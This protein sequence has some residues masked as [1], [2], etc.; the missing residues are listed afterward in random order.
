M[1][2]EE[3]HLIE[4]FASYLSGRSQ[5]VSVGGKCSESLELN[6][7]VPQGSC[8]RPLLF[9]LY[10]SKLFEVVKRHLPSVHAYADDTQLYLAFKPGCASSADDAIAAMER[11]GNEIRAWMLCDKLMI[12]DG[13]TDFVIIGTR[14]QL[15]KVHIDSLAVGDAHVSPVQSVKNLG[16]WI[17]SNMSL[18]VNIN[19]TCRPAYCYITNV[20]Q[21]RKYLSNQATQTLVHA[22][23][24]GRIDY[25][26]SIL[27]G[28]PAKQIAK[29][30]RLQ[31]SA[32]R[33]IFR[34]PRFYHISPILRTLHWLPVEF[35]IQLKIIIITF[36]TIHGQAPVYLQVQEL[37]S[38]K[39]EKRYNLRSCAMEIMLQMPKTLTKKTL[40][41]RAFLA[42]APKLWNGLPSQIRNEP[43][44]N[45]FK[46]LLKTH[47][48]D[49]LFIR[50]IFIF[51]DPLFF[52]IFFVI[53]DNSLINVDNLTSCNAH[54]IIY[55]MYFAQ[56][57]Y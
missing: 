32:A 55:Y 49:K 17:D 37:I 42:T 50:T 16:T 57:E 30:Q 23:I 29:L 22:L 10:A 38:Q 48:L 36:Q 40:G 14:Q 39:K 21:I 25:C 35:R 33:L 53:L 56:Y 3:Q 18:Q 41:D 24:I 4:W 5:R 51:I 43:N 44:F 26:N 47:F 28:L 20:R 7:G 12:N 8:I 15:S 52:I 2:F 46:G 45:R 9:T 34:F 27:Y 6:Q 31:N 1:G 19:N 13:K 54:L 11:C